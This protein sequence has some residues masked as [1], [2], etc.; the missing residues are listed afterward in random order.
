MLVKNGFEGIFHFMNHPEMLPYVG[1]EVL[2][3]GECVNLPEVLPINQI[4]FKIGTKLQR[5]KYL[6]DFMKK[7]GE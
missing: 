2:Y 6:R 3:V 4:Y 1:G 5:P 7:F